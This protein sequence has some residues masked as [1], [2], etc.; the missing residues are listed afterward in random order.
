MNIIYWW[1]LLNWWG[2]RKFEDWRVVH[3]ND[4]M[5]YVEE[6]HFSHGW[7]VHPDSASTQRRDAVAWAHRYY[8]RPSRGEAARTG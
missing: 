8:A 4:N 7:V 1:R 2:L 3:L 5:W 6:R